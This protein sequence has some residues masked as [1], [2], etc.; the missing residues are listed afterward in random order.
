[1][2]YSP[3]DNYIVVERPTSFSKLCKEIDNPEIISQ[4]GSSF[5]I[6]ANVRIT[7]NG[8]LSDQNVSVTV[9][10]PFFQIDKGGKFTLGK[11]TGRGTSGG[12]YFSMPNAELRYG[13]GNE[14]L[15][16]DSTLSG[17]CY[18][19]ASVVDVYCFWGF[20]SG[21]DQHCE[22]VDCLIN[23]FG[24]IEG[25]KS[26]V[27]NVIFEKSHPTYGILGPKGNIAS[28]RKLTSHKSKDC[29]FYYN[30][31]L[32]DDLRVV[33][34][35]FSDYKRLVYCEH[36]VS[37]RKTCRFV[38]VEINGNKSSRMGK[39][40]TLEFAY[41]FNP[42]FTRPNGDRI[43]GSYVRVLNNKD[44]VVYEGST[45]SDG[46]INTELVVWTDS[47]ESPEEYLSPFKVQFQQLDGQDLYQ[48]WEMDIDQPFVGIEIPILDPIEIE[49][50]GSGSS[51][52]VDVDFTIAANAHD[53]IYICS[54]SESNNETKRSG[55]Y[56]Y[57]GEEFVEGA[58]KY[59]DIQK[60]PYSTT[61]S[62]DSLMCNLLA[63]RVKS[64]TMWESND[65]GPWRER[66][67]LKMIDTSGIPLTTVR[68][69]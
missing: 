54:S 10:E 24:R 66:F 57:L 7:S 48:E 22:V 26:V 28:Y 55:I 29:A 34:G 2:Y 63:G 46:S 21:P 69:A 19:Y 61:G 11:K 44:E 37:S 12:C 36:S 23:G 5:L 47:D 4:V 59:V 27:E 52:P 50:E 53:A 56:D 16:N 35:S 43:V 15:F 33:G 68:D 51:S 62:F 38:D 18:L 32:A 40:V 20:F 64:V 14:Q 6:Q 31:V 65:V 39:L 60:T 58:L 49:V 41:T 9:T 67:F 25:T 42:I 3:S 45:G 13:F 17:D 30:P 1:M 8:H